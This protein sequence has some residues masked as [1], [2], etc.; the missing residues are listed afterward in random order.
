[1][2]EY[3]NTVCI[4]IDLRITKRFKHVIIRLQRHCIFNGILCT[5]L[6]LI[7]LSYLYIS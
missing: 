5:R 3:Y 1:M 2:V 6:I 4:K 7:I